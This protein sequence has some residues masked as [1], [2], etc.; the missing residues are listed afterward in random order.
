MRDR[1]FDTASDVQR[2]EQATVQRTPGFSC[3]D[4]TPA[5]PDPYYVLT[6]DGQRWIGDYELTRQ[7]EDYLRAMAGEL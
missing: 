2:T 5:D 6:P 4:F 3:S 7:G 1:F